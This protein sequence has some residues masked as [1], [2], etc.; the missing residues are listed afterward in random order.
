MAESQ[1]V[2]HVKTDG[3]NGSGGPAEVGLARVYKARAKIASGDMVD[4]RHFVATTRMSALFEVEAR[5]RSDNADID[6]EA[7]I[8]QPMTFV[9]EGRSE[10]AWGGVCRELRQIGVEEGG[11][12]TY[13]LSLVPRLWLLTQRRNHRM[14]QLQSEID[15][16]L[17]ILKDWDITPVLRLT[18]TYRKRK[19]RLQYG[20]S[21]FTFISRMLEDAGVSFYF[22]NGEDGKLVLD[23]GPQA[24]TARA[25]IAFRE[26]PLEAMQEFVTKVTVQRSVCPGK[27]TVRDHD[28]R[29]PADYP[30]L[31]SAE[32]GRDVEEGLEQFHYAPGA[33]LYE[34]DKGDATP[35]ADD[36]GKYRADEGEGAALVQRRLDADRRLSRVVRFETNVFD[37]A[38]GSVLSFL[39]HP[40]SELAA[41]K[42]L[43][44]LES[45]LSGD[46]PGQWKHLCTAVSASTQ[47][48]PPLDTP[49]PRALGIECATVVG[50]EG[51]EIH[52]DEF[53]R[54]RVQ[55]H[56]DRE[57]KMNQDSSCW[58][59]V[60][61]PWGGSGFGGTNLPR[62]GQEVIV[63]FL[64]ADPDRPVIT[65]R[66]Y[67]NVQRTPY[68]LPD[69]KTQ[70]GWKSNSSPTTGGYNEMMFEDAAGAELIRIQA[71]K[72]M[73]KLVKHDEETQIGNDRSSAIGHDEDQLVGNDT[74]RSRSSTAS[75]R[76]SG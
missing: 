68:K 21:D 13:E 58:I 10:R 35:Y 59:H 63:D 62:I 69:N 34:S 9:A 19:Y 18:G 33:F 7:V 23:D 47:H 41:D 28:Y 67:T 20:E 24:N 3:S 42:K 72:D 75:A 61:Q 25:P 60:S 29:R 39:D 6:F 51:Q 4:V 26:S 54:V 44:V 30:L 52:V 38:P 27:Y 32:G 50:P 64:G 74:F 65:G 70:S 55:F 14:F 57:G 1:T 31:A 22:E 46:V 48:R 2:G 16:V 15:I 11:L 12:S 43:L 66:V 37:P 56:W 8:G 49:K 53:G 40:K 45:I 36:R 71:E 76:S 17:A 73:H 5:V